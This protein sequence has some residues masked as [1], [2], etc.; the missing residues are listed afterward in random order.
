MSSVRVLQLIDGLNI[1]GAEMM[2]LEL[3][4]GLRERGFHV[5][6]GY[7]TSGPLADI[8]ASRGFEITRL[9]RLCAC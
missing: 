6:V 5:D 1:G 3:C 7:S 8:L 4:T 2:L 9:P